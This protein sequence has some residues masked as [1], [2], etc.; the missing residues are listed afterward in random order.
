MAALALYAAITPVVFQCGEWFMIAISMNSGYEPHPHALLTP[1]IPWGW[2]HDT[3]CDTPKQG[4]IRPYK[5]LGTGII[6]LWL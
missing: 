2:F 4:A 5:D 3:F 6:N 1:E